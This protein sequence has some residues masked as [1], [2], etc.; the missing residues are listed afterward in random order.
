VLTITVLKETKL[1]DG[2]ETQ[3]VEEKETA[4]GQVTEISRN[5]FAFSRK[6]SDVL[7]FGEDVDNYR[8]GKTSGSVFS[9]AMHS[10]VP[11]TFSF[12][13]NVIGSSFTKPMKPLFVNWPIP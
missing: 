3:V 9:R 12:Q 10:A 4:N 6:T 5:Y 1:V 7:Y 8:D 11:I 13:H 2:V